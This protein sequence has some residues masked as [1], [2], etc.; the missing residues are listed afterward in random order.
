MCV[1]G[2]LIRRSP[3]IQALSAANPCLVNWKK[4]DEDFVTAIDFNGQ[5]CTKKESNAHVLATSR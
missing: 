5:V 2:K 3:K 4:M 1:K